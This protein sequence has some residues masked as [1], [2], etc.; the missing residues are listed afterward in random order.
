M[1]YILLCRDC[2]WYDSL[3]VAARILSAAAGYFSAVFGRYVDAGVSFWTAADDLFSTADDGIGGAAHGQH[4][5]WETG[6]EPDCR[7]CRDFAGSVYVSADIVLQSV[8]HFV[9]DRGGVST[10]TVLWI[11]AVSACVEPGSICR[12]AAAVVQVSAGVY[13]GS[14]YLVGGRDTA[15]AAEMDDTIFAPW[16][17]GI[18]GW[19]KIIFFVYNVSV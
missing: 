19:K 10:G 17:A 8:W 6:T 14:R 9:P 1:L 15:A 13:M 5:A 11:C 16:V 2:V 3:S 18:K 4:A 12:E 7:V